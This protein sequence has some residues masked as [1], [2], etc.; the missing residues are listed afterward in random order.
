MTTCRLIK[1]TVSQLSRFCFFA[2]VLFSIFGSLP[3]LVAD[4]ELK[5]EVESTFL[6]GVR[7]L[8]FEGRRAG[9]GYFRSDGKALVFQSEREPGNPFFQIYTMD[10]ETGDVARVSRGI[11]KTTCAWFHPDGRQILFASTQEDPEAVAK[12]KAELLARKEGRQRRYSWDYDEFFDIFFYDTET[13]KYTNL[14][15]VRGYDAEGSVSPDGKWVVFTSNRRAYDGSMTES[16]A[17]R[18]KHDPAVMLDLYRMKSDGT[19]VQ[20][21]TDVP[22]YDGGP[23]FSPD[24]KRICFRRFGLDGATAE[25]MTIN[26]DGTDPK[27]LTKLGALSWAPFYHP[28]GE[29]LIFATNIHGFANFELYLVDTDGRCKPVR[30]TDTAGFDGLPVFSPDGKQL[31]WTS[32]RT[33]QKTSQIFFGEWNHQEA[34]KR[35]GLTSRQAIDTSSARRA[36]GDQA[37]LTEATIQGPDIE[38]HVK[39]LCRE[40]LAG[41]ATGTKGERLATAYVAAYFDHLGLAPAGDAGSYFQTFTFT[42]GIS[43][44]KEN[45]LTWSDKSY[46]TGRDWLPLTFSATGQVEPAPVVFAGYGI[47]APGEGDEGTYD[48]YVHLDVKGKWIVVLR[49][50]PEEIPDEQRQQLNRYANLR[51]KTM[52]ARDKGAAGLIVV[53]GPRTRVKQQLVPLKFSGSMGVG[54]LPVVSVTNAVATAWFKAAGKDLEKIQQQLDRGKQM[55]GFSLSNKKLSAKIDLHQQRRTGRNVLARLQTGPKPTLNYVIVGAHVDHLGR[56]EGGSSLAKDDEREQIHFGADDNASGVGAML[57]IAQYLADQRRSGKLAMKRDVVFAAWSGEELGLLGSHHLVDVEEAA[58]KSKVRGVARGGS[59]TLL[60]RRIAACLNL[61]M[62]GRLRKKLILQGVGSSPIWSQEI[63]RRNVPVGLAISIQQGGFVPSDGASFYQHGVPMLSAFTGAHHEYHT[64]RDLPQTL[65][66]DGAAKVAKLMALI[67]RGLVR[68]DQSPAYAAA[69]SGPSRRRDTNRRVYLGTIPDY[70]G[71]SI[72]G[73]KLSGVTKSG[74]AA[75]AGLEG[76]DVIV[77]LAGKRIE[78]IYDYTY[79]LDALKIGKTAKVV[80][81]RDGKRIVLKIIPE[82][83]N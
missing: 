64:P 4:E 77:E 54:S 31:A 40:E 58:L 1:S 43:L 82:P 34:R 2:T 23:F 26:A 51:Y 33:R 11:G 39:Y 76:G 75:K 72:K 45:S 48:S 41:R 56:G 46:Q 28:S 60:H 15:N 24:G 14:T 18:F 16:E 25:I 65:N 47:L 68:R 70:A 59:V 71:E 17:E 73:L 10:L 62:V 12:Q 61:D 3:N 57:E 21:L 9:E 74:P 29:Y 55:I 22:G 20:R 49:Y 80:V 36:A 35:L 42:A 38:R 78:N 66:Y 50:L 8:T 79:A 6:S 53:S 52:I 37:E 83:R 7:Q 13:N 27:R 63:E 19:G 5:G 44:G 32:N 69:D 67:A 30:V 81:Q